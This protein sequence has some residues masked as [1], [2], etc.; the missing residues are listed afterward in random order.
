ML[1]SQQLCLRRRLRELQDQPEGAAVRGSTG[2]CLHLLAVS[3]L[4][5]R[6]LRGARR[7]PRHR[8][9]RRL[10]RLDPRRRGADGGARGVPAAHEGKPARRRQEVQQQLRGSQLGRPCQRLAHAAVQHEAPGLHHLGR[11]LVAARHA[12]RPADVV[13]A[14]RQRGAQLRVLQGVPERGEL[15]EAPLHR[16]APAVVAEHLDDVRGIL[17]A[18]WALPHLRPRHRGPPRQTG[19]LD[20]TLWSRCAR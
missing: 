5:G 14:W 20:G 11:Q 16:P 1:P 19:R 6:R 10:P 8:T 15:A 13:P 18:V 17:L 12:A 3:I 9:P 7:Y 2:S 4:G